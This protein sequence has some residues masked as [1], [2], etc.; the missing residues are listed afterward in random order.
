MSEKENNSFEHEVEE[1]GKTVNRSFSI[2]E[3][4]LQQ[5]NEATKIYNRALRF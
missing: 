3:A 4:T 1:N 2:T 5:Q